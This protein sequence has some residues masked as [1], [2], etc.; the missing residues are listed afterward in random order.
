MTSGPQVGQWRDL[1]TQRR[2][3]SDDRRADVTVRLGDV[4]EAA[5]RRSFVG[6]R[7]ELARFTE[8]MA[9]RSARRVFLVHG[10]G[11]IGKTTL[12]LEFRARARARDVPHC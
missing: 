9:G 12:L 1:A 6:R 8:S 7:T 10:V 3:E 2:Q 4:V 11:G 5:R